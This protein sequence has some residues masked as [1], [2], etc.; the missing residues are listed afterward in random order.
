[1]RKAEAARLIERLPKYGLK[2]GVLVALGKAFSARRWLHLDHSPRSSVQNAL[3]ELR[4]QGWPVESVWARER[5]GAVLSL[6]IDS[7]AQTWE[8][9]L[10]PEPGEK[11]YRL[12][13]KVFRE[14][15]GWASPMKRKLNPETV[16]RLEAV[17]LL[18]VDRARF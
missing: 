12:T 13:P 4:G 17:G 8:I 14:L 5:R 10:S 1:M 3:S 7:N 2:F 15:R 11:V 16:A 18:P 9:D 6:E